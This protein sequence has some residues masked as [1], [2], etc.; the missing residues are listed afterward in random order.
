M[1]F[2][3]MRIVRVAT[4]E[5]FDAALATADQVIVEGDDQLLSY[6]ATK[7]SQIQSLPELILKP[8]STVNSLPRM[9][10]TC[11]AFPKEISLSYS[12]FF[13]G[14]RA[15]SAGAIPTTGV[16]AAADS[17]DVT[18]EPTEHA[19][20]AAADSGATTV[21]KPV[22]HS[23][24]T[25]ASKIRR[26]QQSYR[27]LRIR[28][29]KQS[30]RLLRNRRWQRSHHRLQARAQQSRRG[31]RLKRLPCRGPPICVPGLALRLPYSELIR[32]G[33]VVYV[34]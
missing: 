13:S 21:S 2:R 6:A 3:P 23:R 22:G 16:F 5:E 18:I 31:P 24:A 10:K 4:K 34:F 26:T 17:N 9:M 1:P 27:R 12:G 11:R 25:A 30:R 15:D 29:A 28:R 20:A 8:S 33:E 32:I 19:R 14:I 7:A